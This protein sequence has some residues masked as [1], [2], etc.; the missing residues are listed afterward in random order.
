LT[1]IDIKVSE[2]DLRRVSMELNAKRVKTEA[3]WQWYLEKLLSLCFDI[4]TI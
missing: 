3:T 4:G 2:R 1:E